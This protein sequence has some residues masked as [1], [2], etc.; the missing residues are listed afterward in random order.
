MLK[1]APIIVLVSYTLS[2]GAMAA[3]RPLSPA[4]RAMIE[5]SIHAQLIDPD[6][7]LFRHNPL[8]LSSDQ[9]CGMVNSKNRLGG[10][11]GYKLFSTKLIKSGGVIKDVEEANIVQTDSKSEGMKG[12]VGM[13]QTSSCAAAGYRVDY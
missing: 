4:E 3:T 2:S 12:L 5:H 8:Q 13:I 6:S 10:Y 11:V 9:Y 7:A 1:H